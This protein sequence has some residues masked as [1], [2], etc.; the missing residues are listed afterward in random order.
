MPCLTQ[1]FTRQPEG[2]PES[3][4]AARTSPLS[5]AALSTRKAVMAFSSP[6]APGP[7]AKYRSIIFCSWVRLIASRVY[8]AG[9]QGRRTREQGRRRRDKR[10]GPAWL[11][12]A[13]AGAWL[14]LSCAASQGGALRPQ[15]LGP[16]G[17]FGRTPPFNRTGCSRKAFFPVGIMASGIG[18]RSGFVCIWRESSQAHSRGAE[19]S[20]SPQ[21][22]R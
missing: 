19:I 8:Q 16:E 17:N 20:G 21:L 18:V 4:E 11:D 14:H 5:R 3:G 15:A 7:A 1:A 22:G 2:E 6:M 13:H 9:E 12:D 10:R